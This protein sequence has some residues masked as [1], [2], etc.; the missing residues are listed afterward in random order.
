MKK[1]VAVVML[2][3]GLSF[4]AFAQEN[5]WRY[6]YEGGNVDL[7]ISENN[8]DGDLIPDEESIIVYNYRT[9]SFI[10]HLGMSA[11]EGCY[12]SEITDTQF[13]V[14]GGGVNC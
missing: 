10:N 3:T 8:Q 2:F 6:T 7:G 9:H 13:Y 4:S 1:Y 5:V 14:M 12:S 11:T